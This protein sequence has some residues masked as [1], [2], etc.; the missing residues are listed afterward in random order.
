MILVCGHPAPAAKSKSGRRVLS[1]FPIDE[2]ENEEPKCSFS[3]ARAVTKRLSRAL[4]D[5]PRAAERSVLTGK[6]S[7][8][9][10]DTSY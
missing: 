6:S 9:S 3:K 7:T 1:F 5:L 8:A 2:E 10:P 4:V